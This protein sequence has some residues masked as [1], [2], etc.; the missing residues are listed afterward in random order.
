MVP[1][2]FEAAA[3]WSLRSWDRTQIPRPFTTV[4]LV[5][6]DPLRVPRDASAEDL[7]QWRTRL[8]TSLGACEARCLEIVRC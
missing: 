5:F 7:E 6:G 3:A 8:E 4:A 1:F 2:H